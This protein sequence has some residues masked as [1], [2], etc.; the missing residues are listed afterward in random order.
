MNDKYSRHAAIQGPQH[1]SW[2]HSQKQNSLSMDS[3]HR[4]RSICIIVV[5]VWK[6]IKQKQRSSTKDYK[7]GS[8]HVSKLRHCRVKFFQLQRYLFHI[9]KP[10]YIELYWSVSSIHAYRSQILY[11]WYFRVVDDMI[12]HITSECTTLAQFSSLH[13]GFQGAISSTRR[14]LC[15][16]F[17]VDSH[18]AKHH[19]NSWFT[20]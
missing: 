20:S 13:Q 16:W 6:R 4:S 19:L 12:S 5:C 10:L 15:H 2:G 1:P 9:T 7:H 3:T 17:L 11:V 18:Q 8:W 14:C